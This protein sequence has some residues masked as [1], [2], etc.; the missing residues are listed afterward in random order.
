MNR[1]VPPGWRVLAI[2]DFRRLWLAH[3]GSVIGD[4]FHA[5]AITWLVFQTLGGGPQA[6]AVLGIA[7]VIPSL[8]LGILSGTIVDRLDRR[9]VMVGTDLARAALVGILAALVAFG[10]ATV[11]VVIVVG[12]VLTVTGLFFYPARNSV[13]P[14]Y[15]ARADLVPANALMSATVQTS[16][17]LAPAIG[18]VLFLVIGPVGLLVIDAVSFVWSAVLIARLTPG[19]A[20]PGTSPRRPLLHEA[21][22]GLRFIAGHP[23]SR[24]CVFTGAANQLFASGPWRVM[25]PTWVAVVLGGGAAEYGTITSAFAAGLLLANVALAGIRTRLP[26]LVLITTGVFLDGVIEIFFAYS[27][28]LVVAAFALFVMGLANAVLNVS[29]STLMQI[30]VPTEMRGRTFATFSTGIQLT[31]PISLAA[32]GALATIAGPVLLLTIAGVGLMGV[33]AVS[34]LATIRGGRE[35]ATAS[36]A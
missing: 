8:A 12:A 36:S 2:P 32:T 17:L 3:V 4:G 18:G 28:T 5:I 7:N 19:P 27:S 34:F 30:S 13:M 31:T 25:V 33:G 1:L 20:I 11:P 29:L 23:P 35:L 22:D 24:L 14:A 6:L 9:R 26:L 21:A 16:Q 15:V 10:Q